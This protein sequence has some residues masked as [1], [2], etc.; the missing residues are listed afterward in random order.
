MEEGMRRLR[1]SAMGPDRI[2]NKM[3]KK[4]SET[5]RKVLLC[6][7][8]LM[9][10]AAYVPDIWKLAW[11]IPI[12]KPNKP[13]REPVSYRPISL[14]S[15]TAKLLEKLINNRL[16]WFVEKNGIIT[17]LQVGFRAHHCTMDQVIRLETAARKATNEGRILAAVFFDIKKAYD[18]T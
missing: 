14:T 1:D 10:E 13:R 6:L 7:F 11:I 17:K 8:N 15:C 16:H 18:E 4:L 2:H 9:Y 5:N 12:L 3:L